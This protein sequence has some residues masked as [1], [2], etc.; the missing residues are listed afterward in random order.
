MVLLGVGGEVEVLGVGQEQRAGLE[1]G[2]I[3]VAV[4]DGLV[5]EA[6]VGAGMDGLTV[7]APD[8]L[9]V[10]DLEGIL[11]RGLSTARAGGLKS[12]QEPMTCEHA[13]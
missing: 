1:P 3:E 6:P 2:G 4:D 9:A 8:L 5:V 7:L 12:G 10:L 13:L 11:D